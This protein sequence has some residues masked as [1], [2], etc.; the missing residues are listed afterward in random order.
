MIEVVC[1]I[2][3]TTNAT[4]PLGIP[5]YFLG[6]RSGKRDYVGCW[7]FPGGKVDP[8]EDRETALKREWKEELGIEID[9]LSFFAEHPFLVSLGRISVSAYFVRPRVQMPDIVLDPNVFDVAGPEYITA[10]FRPCTPAAAYLL[11]KLW[12]NFVATRNF[13]A[14]GTSV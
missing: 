1:G 14:R 3:D 9:V 7:E 4:N 11:E 2:W 5:S 12:G 6:R 13:D 8:G 10:Y